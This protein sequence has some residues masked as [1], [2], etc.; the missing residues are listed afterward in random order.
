[1]KKKIKKLLTFLF[2]IKSTV[3]ISGIIL[4]F[5]LY[6]SNLG[7]FLQQKTANELA[8]GFNQWQNI[9]VHIF[10][11]ASYEHLIANLFALII[12][13]I[14]FE[15]KT[16]SKKM[17]LIFL[18]AG[19]LTA[20]VFLLF[21]SDFV[22]VGASAAIS[23]IIATAMAVNPKK[24]LYA[25]IA[26]I[27]LSF[28]FINASK[29]SINNINIGLK[30]EKIESL[31]KLEK[32]IESGDKQKEILIQKKIEKIEKKETEI[33]KGEQFKSETITS[34]WPHLMGA[35]FGIIALFIIDKKKI[36]EGRNEFKEMIQ[37]FGK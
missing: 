28:I 30:E 2:K 18:T 6:L 22:L 37:N 13:G 14:I 31:Q 8:F 1:M 3:I 16:D 19:L 36:D 20:P 24:F 35:L 29:I 7:F 34:P 10:V 23:G 26:V 15:M 17:L 21:E 25:L 9:L 27:F 33:L 5:Y 12:F 4:V 32:A 11:H